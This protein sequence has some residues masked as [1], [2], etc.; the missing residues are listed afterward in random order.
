M[1]TPIENQIFNRRKE[2]VLCYTNINLLC[3]GRRIKHTVA[4]LAKLIKIKFA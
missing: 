4:E 3:S 2:L 1:T